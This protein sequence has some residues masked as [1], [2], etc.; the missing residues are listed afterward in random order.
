MIGRLKEQAG[1]LCSM[2]IAGS[3]LLLKASFVG[4]YLRFSMNALLASSIT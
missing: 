2:P 4:Y 3:G 1:Y